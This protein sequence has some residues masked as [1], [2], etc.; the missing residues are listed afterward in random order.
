VRLAAAGAVGFNTVEF[1]DAR[2]YLFAATELARSGRYP[3]RT[4]PFYFRA[5]GYPFFL[6]IA[7]LAK[8]ESVA[9][10]KIAT[11]SV[12]SLA[13]PLLALLSARIFR[14]RRVA[15]A[16]GVAAALHPAFLWNSADVQSE[17]LFTTLL[18]A[19]G[20]LLLAATDRPSSGLA[21]GAGVF[22]ALS[23]LTRASALVLSPFLAAPLFDRRYPIR[24]RAH[25]AA[26]GVFGFALAL[27]PWTVRNGVVFGE[28]V[29]VN[30]A[31][32]N[33]FYQGNSDWAMRFFEIG[34]RSEYLRWVEELHRDMARQTEALRRSGK[35]SPSE[36]SRAFIERAIEERRQDPA[37]WA[38]LLA[39][40]A[41]EWLRPYPTPWFWPPSVVVATGLYYLVLY[42]FAAMGLVDAPRGGVRA[43]A[44]GILAVSF[45]AHVVILVVWRYRVPYWDPVLL[46]YGVF[47]AGGT[48]LPRWKF[49]A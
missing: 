36:R 11:A 13:A 18:L 7:T 1:G 34:S 9:R 20:L 10:A 37:G 8:P 43:F 4:E 22:L 32:G 42:A 35:I 15:L 44:L 2:A 16:T 29:P 47:G 19:A 25:L 3:L 49:S 26:A 46:L 6:A 48:L 21:V 23:A 5:P 39:R 30:D 27:A 17:P 41:W 14:R 31:S 28:L 12:G 24:A 33:A 38:R 45:A 40:K